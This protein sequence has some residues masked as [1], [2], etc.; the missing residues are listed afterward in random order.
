MSGASAWIESF[1]IEP[2]PVRCINVA[3]V[4]ELEVEVKFSIKLEDLSPL[5]LEA[6][7]RWKRVHRGEL[8]VKDNVIL[9]ADFAREDIH[10]KWHEQRVDV[11]ET[12]KHSKSCSRLLLWYLLPILRSW[13]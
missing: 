1:A 13:L 12:N 3:V 8:I 10:H 4:V 7:F 6:I 11:Q 9:R 2:R 5:I